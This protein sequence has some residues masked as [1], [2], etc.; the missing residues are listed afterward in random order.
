MF[1]KDVSL[2]AIYP[3]SFPLQRASK[4]AQKAFYMIFAATC[5]PIIRIV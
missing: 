3:P 2:M 4:A 1:R 5:N